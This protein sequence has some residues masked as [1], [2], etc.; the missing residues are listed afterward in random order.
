MKL[1][2]FIKVQHTGDTDLGQADMWWHIDVQADWRKIWTYCRVPDISEGYLT[3][4][5]KYQHGVTLL[6]VYFEN[7][8]FHSP[9]TTRMAIRT[10]SPHLYPSGF[11]PVFRRFLL[12]HRITAIILT[13]TYIVALLQLF[14]LTS[15]LYTP[16]GFT[17]TILITTLF[18]PDIYQLRHFL[19]QQF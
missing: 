5:S 16:T 3:C 2:F 14:F 17:S 9:F 4:P 10:A 15:P 19:L 13:P 18:T 7:A 11:I 12:R 6:T 1:Y 8:P